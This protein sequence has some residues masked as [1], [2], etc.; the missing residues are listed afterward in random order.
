MCEIEKSVV[1]PLDEEGLFRRECPFCKREFKVLVT[2]EELS[3]IAQKGIET[4]LLENEE[5]DEEEQE[6]VEPE[7]FCPYC[8]QRASRSNWWTREQAA[9]IRVI[10]GNIAADL[11]NKHFIRPLQRNLNKSN[12]AVRFEGKPMVQHEPWISPEENDMKI[13]DLPCCQRQIKVED[14]WPNGIFC[15]FCGFPHQ[16]G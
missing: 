5:P 12:S 3:D 9:Y 14:D 7:F 8:G 13:I 10:V 1:F 11:I 2:K 16:A 15:Y 6:A 4:F